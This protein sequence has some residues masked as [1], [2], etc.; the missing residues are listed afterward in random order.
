M[1]DLFRIASGMVQD[2]AP[3][4]VRFGEIT[5]VQANRTCTVNVGGADVAGVKYAA[6]MAPCPGKVA[7]LLTDGADLFAVD[8]MAAADL[9][10]APR[11]SRNANLTVANTTDTAVTWAA[12]NSDAWGCWNAASP[13]YLSAPLTGRYMAT[14]QVEFAGDADGFRQAWIRRNGTSVLGYDK[15]ISAAAASPTD[16]TVAA[17]SFDMTKGDY[18]ELIVR[19]NAGNDLVLNYDSSHNP[20]LSLIYL[21]P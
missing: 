7:F 6:G 13:T 12:V 14:A 11:A 8:H 16:M 15:A 17:P 2:A 19:H 21:G 9:T 4:R 3:I 1:S 20:S 5:S 10:L 18:I